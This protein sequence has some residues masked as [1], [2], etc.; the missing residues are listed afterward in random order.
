MSWDPVWEEVHRGRSWGKYPP[1]ELVRFVARNY[2]A[3]PDRRAVRL[4]EVG[5][6][7]GANLWFMAREGFSTYGVEGSETAAATARQRLDK[8]CPGWA[9]E[10]RAGDII[11]LSYPD[12]FFDAVIDID[13]VCCNSFDNARAIYAEMARVCKPGGRL[14]SKTLAAGCWGDGTG[15]SVGHRA[16]RA[17][18]G[19][20][21][22]LGYCRFT[23]AEEV[24]DLIKPFRVESVE[25]LTRTLDNRRHE[26]RELAIQG[27]K[28]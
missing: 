1:E 27:V 21:A 14:F 25:V 23:A 16:W 4:L 28:P 7:T 17:S 24:P 26:V 6:A 20:L 12:G 8:E 3:A 10:V 9:G 19:P 13:A 2:Y 22:G 15:T 5:C 18:E 11:K